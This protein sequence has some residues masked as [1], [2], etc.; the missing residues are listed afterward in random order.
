MDNTTYNGWTNY[1]TWRVALECFDGM[2]SCKGMDAETCEDMV[3]ENIYRQSEG[4][5]ND[6]AMAFLSEV[7]WHEIAEHL[8]D[9]EE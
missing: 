6:Y 2:D 1:A 9:E 4:L 3:V 5:A 8:K 7:N